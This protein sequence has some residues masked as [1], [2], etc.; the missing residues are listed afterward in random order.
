MASPTKKVRLIRKRKKSKM[1]K[2]RKAENR[3]NGTTQS[4]EELFGD[5]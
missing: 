1:G 2:E 4:Y 5:K 3:N